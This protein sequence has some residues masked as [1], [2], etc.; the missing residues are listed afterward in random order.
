MMYFLKFIYQAF[1]LPPG[2]FIFT[3]LGIGLWFRYKKERCWKLIV[4]LTCIFYLFTTNFTARL[5]LMPLE[6]R[7]EPPKQP[8]GDIIVM[9]G[10]GAHAD[11]PNVNGVG[12]ISGYGAN[13]LLT[14]VQ[15]YHQLDVPILVSGGQVFQ[16]SG[17]E[18]EIAKTTLL[19]LGIPANKIL[20]EKESLNTTQNAQYTA[21]ILESRGFT[22]PILVT[23]AFHMARA[24]G[25]FAKVRVAVIPYPSDYQTNRRLFLTVFDFI[26]SA[27]A[28]EKISLAVKEYIGLLAVR[29][30]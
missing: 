12:Q 13:R 24:I 18:A 27:D 10:A 30:Y 17:N 14:C 20:V 7:Y 9:L 11:V 3:F 26:P 25:Q 15:L 22:R 29:W 6:Q 16:G 21:R 5:L 8:G 4:V 23:S 19:G 2:I 1:F 28:A